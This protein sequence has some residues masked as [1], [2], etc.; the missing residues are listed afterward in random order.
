MIEK[1]SASEYIIETILPHQGGFY[2]ENIGEDA[3]LEVFIDWETGEVSDRFFVL[4]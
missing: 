2:I 3:V 1:E 4:H